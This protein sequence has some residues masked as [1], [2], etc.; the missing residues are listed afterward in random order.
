MSSDNH[1]HFIIPLKYYVGTL[2][3]LIILTIITVASSRIDLGILNMP[4][5]L[6]LAVTKATL[7]ILFFMGMRWEKG[8]SVIMVL[9]SVMCIIIFF[10]LTFSDLAYRDIIDPETDHLFNTKSKVIKLQESHHK[11]K[12]AH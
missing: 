3:G 12:G 9:G 4:L 1:G 5:A 11:N 2:I 8:I 10:L 6:S 7:V